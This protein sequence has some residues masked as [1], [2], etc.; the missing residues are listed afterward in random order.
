MNFMNFCCWKQFSFFASDPYVASGTG[1]IEKDYDAAKERI[2]HY[3]QNKYIH[4]SKEIQVALQLCQKRPEKL[5]RYAPT[6]GDQEK[7]DRIID[8]IHIIDI[9]DL[10]DTIDLIDIQRKGEKRKE[11][12]R[13]KRRKIEKREK[14]REEGR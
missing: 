8:I 9:M 7:T 6:K 4:F 2:G 13:K 12:E 1:K 10:L 14:R 5:R 3:W 11:T